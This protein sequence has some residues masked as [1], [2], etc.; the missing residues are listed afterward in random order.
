MLQQEKPDDYV[1]A[2]GVTTTVREFCNLAFGEIGVSLIWKGEGDKEIGVNSKSNK[3]LVE[4]DS[5][6][7]RPTEVDLLVGDPS[8]ARNE[9]GWYST[10]NVSDLVKEMVAS[11]LEIFKRQI[12]LKKGG[13]NT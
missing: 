8:K 13:F 11:D 4:V 2:T 10:T 3:V 6:Y 9:L 7:Y 5:N 1:L 12:H